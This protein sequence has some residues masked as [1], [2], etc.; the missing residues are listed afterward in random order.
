ML[1]ADRPSFT[2]FEVTDHS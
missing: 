1:S 2:K